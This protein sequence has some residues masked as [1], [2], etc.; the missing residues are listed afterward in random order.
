MLTVGIPETDEITG[1]GADDAPRGALGRLAEDE[2][3]GAAVAKQ[4]PLWVENLF[5]FA[6]V[7]SVGGLI[8]GEPAQ[9]RRLLPADLQPASRRAA[10]RRSTAPSA[11][12]PWSRSSSRATAT[13]FEY[14]SR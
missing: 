1:Q 10:T 5:L 13:V 2:A 14:A 7:W 3:K 8:D 9:V 6:L 11:S 12:R 4:L